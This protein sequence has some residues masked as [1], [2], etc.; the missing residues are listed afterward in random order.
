[1]QFKNIIYTNSHLKGNALCTWSDVAPWWVG[2][3]ICRRGVKPCCP[4]LSHCE[5]VRRYRVAYSWQMA[6]V[7]KH[8]VIRKTGST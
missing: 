1:M 4:L 5:Y 6:V 7:S 8:G 3:S 2:L